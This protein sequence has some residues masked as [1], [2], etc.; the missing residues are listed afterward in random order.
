M[1]KIADSLNI[2]VFILAS[3]TIMGFVYQGFAL[4]RFLVITV[5]II[6]TDGFFILSTVTNLICYRKEKIILYFSMFSAIII[7]LAVGLKLMGIEYP[8]LALTFWWFYIWL[9]Y[10][11]MLARRLRN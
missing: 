4:E 5:M 1:K 11:G 2:L 6:I 3:L 9:Y 7:L 8:A 10:G